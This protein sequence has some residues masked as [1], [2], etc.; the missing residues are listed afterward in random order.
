MLVCNHLQLLC[1]TMED[2]FSFYGIPAN[3]DITSAHSNFVRP[4]FHPILLTLIKGINFLIEIF[5][6]FP[7]IINHI[8]FAINHKSIVGYFYRDLFTF[9]IE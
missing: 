8:I 7:I 9:T 5:S 3:P 2:P 1:K 6:V 4:L